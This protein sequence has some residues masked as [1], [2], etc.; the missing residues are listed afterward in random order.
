MEIFDL[1]NIE[2]GTDREQK[3]KILFEKDGIK[4]RTIFLGPDDRIPP[5]DMTSHVIFH[6][7]EGSVDIT[8]NDKTHTLQEG[9][10]IVTEPATISM[11]S[12]NGSRLLGIQISRNGS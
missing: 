11:R 4:M 8:V 1:K 9:T 10:C 5:C 12:S 6:V 2:K 7:V 3:S